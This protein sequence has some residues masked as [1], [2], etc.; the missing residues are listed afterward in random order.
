VTP[1]EV[2]ARIA[3][4]RAAF[5]AQATKAVEKLGSSDPSG[6]FS[7]AATERSRELRDAVMQ[8][9]TERTTGAYAGL[10]QDFV[11]G[12]AERDP[13]AVLTA[14]FGSGITARQ[15]KDKVLLSI[16]GRG[17]MDFKVALKAGLITVKGA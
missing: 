16:P 14:D 17:E 7:W 12:V 6:F 3:Q 2:T 10:Y 11:S 5:A 8:H 13:A 9:A 1:D 15:V 4:A